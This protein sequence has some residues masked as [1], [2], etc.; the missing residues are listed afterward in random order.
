MEPDTLHSIAH[1]LF[2]AMAEVTWKDQPLDQIELAVQSLVSQLANSLMQDFILPILI[3][4]IHQRVEDGLLRCP[5]CDAKLQLHKQNQ[6]IHPK[7]IFGDKIRLA[8]HQYYCAACDSYQMVADQQL[9]LPPQQMTPRLALVTMLCGASWPYAVSQAFLD[10]L[11]GVQM[12]ARTVENVATHARLQVAELA[13]DPLD[14]PP[15]VVTADGVLIRGREKEQWL[16][17]KVASFFSQVV[18]V[19][20]DRKEVMDAS[21]AASACQTWS[22]FVEPVTK[23]AER[24]G[25]AGREE[26]EF[27]CDGASGIWS[28]C[29]MVFPY[30]KPRLDLYHAKRKLSRRTRQAYD[31]NPRQKAHQ[32]HLQGCLE[33]G[34]IDTAIAYLQKHLPK[35]EYKKTAA[36]K[37]MGYLRRNQERIPNYEQVKA[38]G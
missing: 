26:V 19:S 18:E 1:L 4:D 20:K 9:D 10:F 5:T 16:E 21:F 30:A 3:R 23:E 22:E 36:A 32:E 27:V 6:A 33:R 28:L 13:P 7:T 25:L 8:R 2:Q 11:F 34:Q 14:Q 15:G 12:S 37:L 31:R 35:D 29:E 17:M 24:R 38:E